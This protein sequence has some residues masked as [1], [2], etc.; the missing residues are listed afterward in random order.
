MRQR[1]QLTTAEYFALPHANN[2]GIKE[3]HELFLAN[4]RG[5]YDLTK[6]YRFGSAFDALLTEPG[7]LDLTGM[8]DSEVKTVLNM[9]KSLKENLIYN[10][11]FQS[12]DHQ[13][14]FVEEDDFYLGIK[15]KCKYDLWNEKLDF[16]GDIKTTTA[17]TQ[18]QFEA[19]AKFMDYPRQAAWYMDITNTARFVI[20]GISKV[21]LKTFVI[22]INKGSELYNA[23][24]EQYELFAESWWKLNQ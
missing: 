11:L 23:G 13:A 17:T 10:T 8:E 20:I 21:N 16:G 2:S 9:R 22:N 5:S 14:V 4:N 18:S 15:A 1:L 3:A 6:A 7:E 24:K 12:H 19:A